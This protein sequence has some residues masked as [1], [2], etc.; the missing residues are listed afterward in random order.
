MIWIGIIIGCVGGI[1]A[2]AVLPKKPKKRNR[3]DWSWKGFLDPETS[4]KDW[5][6]PV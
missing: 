3:Y 5:G 2:A 6:R 1:I 4:P